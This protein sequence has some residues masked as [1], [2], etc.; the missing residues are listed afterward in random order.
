MPEDTIP[1]AEQ[2]SRR[3]VPW[4]SFPEL[5]CSPLCSRVC[6]YSEVKDTPTLVRQ[7][8]EDVQN[9]KT[10]GRHGEEVHGYKA[11]PVIFEKSPPPL[12]RRLAVPNEILAH[13]GLPDVDAEL[14]Q[15]AVHAW[16][17]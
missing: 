9:L 8:K 7:D 14:E 1:I 16:R 11:L 2:I 4:K 10:D 5:L 6:G 17:S 3:G 12:G 13:A 15:L